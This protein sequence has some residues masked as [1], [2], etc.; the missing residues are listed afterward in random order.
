MTPSWCGTN[1]LQY[2][3]TIIYLINARFSWMIK[4]KQTLCSSCYVRHWSNR[5]SFKV[6]H[7]KTFHNLGDTVHFPQLRISPQRD[8][9]LADHLGA[10]VFSWQ[11]KGSL[12]VTQLVR[13]T[14][15]VSGSSQHKRSDLLQLERKNEGR[16]GEWDKLI[17]CSVSQIWRCT[18]CESERAVFWD[19]LRPLG[20]PSH[21]CRQTAPLWS[22]S[23]APLALCSSRSGHRKTLHVTFDYHD[24]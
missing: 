5:Q 12:H 2:R 15:I 17:F 21:V 13:E 8:A 7:P 3:G 20:A 4:A 9:G 19:L 16:E 22:W 23:S 11:F 10:Q 14:L 24:V 1:T 6:N 18:L